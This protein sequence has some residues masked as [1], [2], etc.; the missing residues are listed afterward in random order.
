MD[1]M[2]LM[3]KNTPV[4]KFEEFGGSIMT[5]GEVF[6][7][8]HI[9]VGVGQ[10]PTY[11]SLSSWDKMRCIPV[12][13]YGYEHICKCLGCSISE[14]KSLTHRLSLTDCYWTKKEDETLTWEDVNYHKNGFSDELSQ[15]IACQYEHFV[16]NK[17]T[18][19]LTTDGVLSKT[20]ILQEGTPYLLKRG[21]IPGLISEN[22][23]SANEIIASK[24]A[25]EIGIKTAPYYSVRIENT[26]EVLCK[27]PSFVQ[28][29]KEEF[30][31]ALQIAKETYL[32]GKELFRW[33]VKN[34]M[35]MDIEKMIHLNVLIG[36]IDCHEKN[37]GII[38][39][40]DTLEI[41]RFADLYDMGSS[42]RF[43]G[44]LEYMKPFGDTR[45][46]NL[47]LIKHEYKLPDKEYVGDLI[48]DHYKQFGT[49]KY[50]DNAIRE[51]N[52]GFC[53]IKIRQRELSDVSLEI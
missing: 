43:N 18:P 45:K 14:A 32:Y 7:Q 27:T 12:D 40:P 34:G 30:V 1:K 23:L 8:E 10:T 41:I 20:W 5:V 9:P 4:L 29:D 38:R 46:E 16:T 13:R 2:I 42:F 22:L 39:D 37:F 24:I 21:N 19:D 52:D 53:A 17:S 36:N 11:S 6:S 47:S 50:I 25:K 31:N 33:F 28:G 51:F 44:P 49:T 26:G 15:A 3:H 48:R 35:Q